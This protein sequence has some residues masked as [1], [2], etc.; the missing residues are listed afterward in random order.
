MRFFPIVDD[1]QD[2]AL[3]FACLM[4]ARAR[5]EAEVGNLQNAVTG[6]ETFSEQPCNQWPADKRPG[7]MVKLIREKLGDIE[8][9]QPIRTVLTRAIKPTRDRNLLAH[10]MWWRFHL[11]TSTLTVRHGTARPGEPVQVD[12]TADGIKRVAE[13]FLDLEAELFNLR[14]DIER[15][16]IEADWPYFE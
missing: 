4:V 3:A 6:D 16:W 10:G 13:T 7:R 14:R 11:E 5:F 9:I 2:H 15:N 8:E 1:V 12:W